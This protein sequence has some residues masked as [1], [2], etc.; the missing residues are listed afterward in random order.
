[1]SAF[2]RRRGEREEKPGAGSH[3]WWV[4]C[5]VAVVLATLLGPEPRVPLQH[6]YLDPGSGSLIIQAV[7]AAVAGA[8]VLLRTY[9][10]KVRAL[11]GFSPTSDRDEDA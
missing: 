8:A 3:L 1:M 2:L 5:V 9:W 6:A 4:L 11:F 7:L 10:D